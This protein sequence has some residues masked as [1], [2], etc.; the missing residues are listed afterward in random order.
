MNDRNKCSLSDAPVPIWANDTTVCFLHGFGSDG[1]EFR[2]LWRSRGKGPNR[3]FLD[4]P[5]LDALTSKRRWLPFSNVP[6]TLASGVTAAADL[7]ERELP[8]YELPTHLVLAG[9]SQG[10]MVCLELVRRRHI[11]VSAVWCYCGYLPEPLRVPYSDTAGHIEMHLLWSHKDPFIMLWDVEETALFFRDQP[12]MHVHVH[13]SRSLSHGF[14]PDW[15][16]ARNF[17]INVDLPSH[18]KL[19]IEHSFANIKRERGQ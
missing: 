11:N 16:E 19:S 10:A 13:V 8:E 15:L 5:E 1:A 12:G 9:H 7:V 18:G 14:S 4:G 6:E 3:L 17:D 2:K